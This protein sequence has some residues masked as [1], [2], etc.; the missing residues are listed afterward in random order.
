MIWFCYSCKKTLFFIWG[1][2]HSDRFLRKL[3]PKIE[4]FRGFAKFVLELP[5]YLIESPNVFHCKP[6][7]KKVK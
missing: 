4:T 7:K 1:V 2:A 5:D 3:G 6:E